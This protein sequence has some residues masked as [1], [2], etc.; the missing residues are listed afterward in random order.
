MRHGRKNRTFGRKANVRRGFIRS[1]AVALISHGAI[2]TTEAPHYRRFAMRH[3]A[4]P[5]A[6]PVNGR[7]AARGRTYRAPLGVRDG[8]GITF[9]SHTGEIFPAGFRPLTCGKFPHDSIVDIYQHHPTFVALRDSDQL[10]GKCGTCD[11][12]DVCGGSRSRAFAV[13]GDPL[14]AEPDCVYSGHGSMLE[15]CAV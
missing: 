7:H 14:A 15:D 13:H 4:D 3:N 8:R 5:L 6:E 2:K 12:N 10:K 1:L 9:V 11:Y